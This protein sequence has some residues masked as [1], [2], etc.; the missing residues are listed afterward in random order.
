MWDRNCFGLGFGAYGSCMACR[1]EG[2]S[3]GLGIL[4]NRN[5]FLRVDKCSIESSCRCYVDCASVGD[6]PSYLW[7]ISTR[8]ARLASLRH[9][10]AFTRERFAVAVLMTIIP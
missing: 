9:E 8:H 4:A 3:Q 1:V 2:I 6:C 7:L 5:C 10:P